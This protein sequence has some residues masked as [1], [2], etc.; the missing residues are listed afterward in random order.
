MRSSGIPLQGKR[1]S[2]GSLW[3]FWSWVPTHRHH[4]PLGTA[5]ELVLGSLVHTEARDIRFLLSDIPDAAI[6]RKSVV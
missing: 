4:R 6:D 3:T 1:H 2:P 5:E